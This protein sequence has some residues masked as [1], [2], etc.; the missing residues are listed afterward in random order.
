[1][2]VPMLMILGRPFAPRFVAL[3]T[4]FLAVLLALAS[5]R[6]GARP[7][8]L[9]AAIYAAVSVVGLSTMYGGFA[10]S[11][12]GEAL[13]RLRAEVRPDDAVI[14]NGPWQDIL[15]RR[16]GAGLPP[17]RVIASTVPLQIDE[18][19]GWLQR[20][21]A[22]HPRVWVVDTAT[23]AADPTGA[24]AAWLDANAY[25]RPVIE[26]QKAVL[27]PYLTEIGTTLEAR[28]TDAA[29]L[30]VRFTSVALDRRALALG[31]EARLRIEGQRAGGS[32]AALR[33]VADL[34]SPGG[35]S[36]WHWDG[37]LAGSTRLTY[38]ASVLVPPDTTPG[39][40]RLQGTVYET[41]TTAGPAHPVRAISE[42]VTLDRLTVRG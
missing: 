35:A 16:Y 28:P 4:P 3:A 14:L 7:L 15:Y 2:G 11:D 6:L 8:A 38:R 12:Y 33:F 41:D 27:R 18:S 22:E 40:Y 1:V 39:D 20:I 21:T 37:P 13:A 34:V 9:C 17:G 26:Y 31:S 29:A 19:I 25:P 24:V 42:P 30:G 5:R 10:R 32:E 23:D 36:V